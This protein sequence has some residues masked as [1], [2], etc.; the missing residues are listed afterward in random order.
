MYN[1]YP[2]GIALYEKIQKIKVNYPQLERAVGVFIGD[3]NKYFNQIDRNIKDA[4]TKKYLY[5][6][7]KEYRQN[8]VR[9]IVRLEP[10]ASYVQNVVNTIYKE[11]L[12]NVQ[13]SRT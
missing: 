5:F 11:K 2:A 3:T 4:K 8:H 12:K 10:V 6:V 7:L 9:H 1:N 13:N